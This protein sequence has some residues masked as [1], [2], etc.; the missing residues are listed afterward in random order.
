MVNLIN[1]DKS[2]SFLFIYLPPII[3]L[4]SSKLICPSPFISASLIM[5]SNSCSDKASFKE[6][7]TLCNSLRSITPLPSASNTL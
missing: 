6:D 1:S 2:C 7:I 3:A 4:N 5:A